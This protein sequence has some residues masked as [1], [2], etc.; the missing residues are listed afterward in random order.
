MFREITMNRIFAFPLNLYITLFIILSSFL[1]SYVQIVCPYFSCALLRTVVFQPFKLWMLEVTIW[2]VDII[3]GIVRLQMQMSM[4]LFWTPCW[5]FEISMA[6]RCHL[7]C[8]P[9][10]GSIGGESVMPQTMTTSDT[11]EACHCR[12]HEASLSANVDKLF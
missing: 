1:L 10:S 3:I 12:H 11:C 9:F 8:F 5:Y 4:G 2:C 6:T 7:R